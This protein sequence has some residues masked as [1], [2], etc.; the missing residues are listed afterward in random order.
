MHSLFAIKQCSIKQSGLTLLVVLS[1]ALSVYGQLP[2]CPRP[3]MA[4][5]AHLSGEW[6]VTLAYRLAGELIVADSAYAEIEL[7][8]GNCALIEKVQ[9][10]LSG[11]TLEI[12]KFLVAPTQETLRQGYVDSFHGDMSV[13]QGY[14]RGDT[15]RFERSRDWGTHIQLIEHTYFDIEAN[16]FRTEA[17]MSPDNG[18]HWIVVQHATYR[19]RF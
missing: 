10:S 11:Q 8:A 13:S 16:T 14:V 6:T 4:P 1:C 5:L 18:A 19:R 15:V 3:P 17:R 2:D 12:A 9:A 7:A